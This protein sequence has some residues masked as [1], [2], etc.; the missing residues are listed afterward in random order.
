MDSYNNDILIE[1]EYETITNTSMICQLN[2]IQE[3]LEVGI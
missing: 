2:E 3:R 1:V